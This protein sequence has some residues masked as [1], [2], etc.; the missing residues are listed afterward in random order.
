M[1]TIT[2]ILIGVALLGLWWWQQDTSEFRLRSFFAGNDSAS[3]FVMV[4]P[5]RD[6]PAD[7][8]II[9]APPNC[10]RP[11]GQRARELSNLLTEEGIPNMISPRFSLDMSPSDERFSEA[12]KNMKFV[13][14]KDGP[15]VVINH[16]GYPN[17]PFDK[18]IAEYSR[19]T[20]RTR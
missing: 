20:G 8:V 14:E 5:G 19:Q 1:R 13:F 7:M 3:G 2:L 17:P 6:L 16:M 9:M 18:I 15:P 11:A 4:G 10:P 12:V